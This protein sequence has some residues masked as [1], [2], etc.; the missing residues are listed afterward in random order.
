MTEWILL[1]WLV[2]G[3]HRMQP[4]DEGLCRLVDARVA[5]GE[6]LS[7]E[8]ADGSSVEVRWAV[9]LPPTP[10]CDDEPEAAS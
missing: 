5:A 10:D 2:T 8:L 7:I 6:G 9:C 4:V 1:I 3:E